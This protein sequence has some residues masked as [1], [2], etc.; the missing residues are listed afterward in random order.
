MIGS[1]SETLLYLQDK[2]TRAKVL[3]Q[4]CFTVREWRKAEKNF[5][6]ITEQYPSWFDFT[7]PLIVRSSALSEDQVEQSCAGHFTSVTNVVGDDML[8]EA[9]D[10]V[11]VLL[12]DKIVTIRFLFNQCLKKL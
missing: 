3:P 12:M 1:K 6:K 4:I 2:I 11:V 9:I 10:V 8:V 7:T 5:T